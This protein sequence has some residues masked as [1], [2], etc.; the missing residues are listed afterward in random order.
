MG[1]LDLKKY[2]VS[3]IKV[4][5]SYIDENGDPHEGATKMVGCYECDIVPAGGSNNQITF[6]DGEVDYYSYTIY[7]PADCREF[8]RG[9][10]IIVK[11]FDIE[12]E[13]VVKGFQ[14]YQLQSKIWV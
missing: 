8:K 11:R 7:L 4:E 1:V 3:A 12:K 9:E 13:Y 5:E 2:C 10:K 6:G 14:R